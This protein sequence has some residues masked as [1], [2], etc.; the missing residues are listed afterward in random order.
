MSERID[1]LFCLRL[2]CKRAI[3][4]G[5]R[6]D[7]K[8]CFGQ[9]GLRDDL[10]CRI[11]RL[12]HNMGRII[13]TSRGGGDFAVVLR[14][15][16]SGLIPVMAQRLDFSCLFLAAAAAYMPV[17]DFVVRPGGAGVPQRFRRLSR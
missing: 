16:I 13:L 6:V 8:A 9:R 3:R 2:R 15:D 12:R 14:P 7:A 17:G 4:E 11:N 5:R 1:I 10:V